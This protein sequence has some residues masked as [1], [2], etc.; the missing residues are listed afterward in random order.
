MMIL[1]GAMGTMIQR[2][3]LT[4]KDFGKGRLGC[5]DVLV[6][7]R[8]D[9]I[10]EIH[11][12][13]LAAGADIIETNTFNA[14]SISMEEYGLQDKV[15]EINIA[16]AR[17]AR[18]AAD[19][20]G[21]ERRRLVAGSM[22][23]TNVALSLGEVADA[24]GVDYEKMR[25][26]YSEQASALIEGGADLLLLETIFDTLN[27]KAAIAGIEDAFRDAHRRLPL[28]IS[29]TLTEQGRTLSG[30]NLEAFVASVAHAR[31]WSIGMNCG[32][33][34]EEM[35]PWLKQLREVTSRILPGV[36]I[37]LHPNAGL[38]DELGEYTETPAEMAT[39]MRRY[40]E[41]GLD[42]AGGCCG[43]TPQHIAAL[44]ATAE[45]LEKSE[46]SEKLEKLEEL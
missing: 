19:A 27:A 11:K 16:G 41:D 14:N 25:R 31:P 20:A 6:L 15:K 35:A 39:T 2:Y 18:E 45:E 12:A 40:M 13:Y 28:M 32:F 33:G 37:S 21:G 8:P 30:Q 1:D 22:G 10:G 29:V 5:N 24:R 17:L 4:E 3:E 43:T 46:E 42:I 26:A 34:A 44:K 9:V 23:P 7:T 36:K 38:P